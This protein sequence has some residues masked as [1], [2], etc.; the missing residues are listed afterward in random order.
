MKKSYL[1]LESES[2][3]SRM[4]KEIASFM[5]SKRNVVIEFEN[6]NRGDLTFLCDVTEYISV[7][8]FW[9]WNWKD[10]NQALM[11]IH[12]AVKGNSNKTDFTGRAK[13]QQEKVQI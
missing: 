8:D 3:F 11:N 13:M 7:L 1:L 6:E 12:A 2:I 9:M 4:C 10:T 5:V